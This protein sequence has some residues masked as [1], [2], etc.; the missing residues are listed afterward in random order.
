MHYFFY[1][2]IKTYCTS[3]ELHLIGV[4]RYNIPFLDLKVTCFACLYYSIC[5]LGVYKYFFGLIDLIESILGITQHMITIQL[6]LYHINKINYYMYALKYP[7]IIFAQQKSHNRDSLMA[8]CVL[9]TSI[10][11]FYL[12]IFSKYFQY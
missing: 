8:G 1:I 10:L 12:A 5:L 11:L 6:L 3:I 7:R 2:R 4:I 9:H